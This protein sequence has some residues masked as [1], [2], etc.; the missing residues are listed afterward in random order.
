[1]FKLNFEIGVNLEKS[2]VNETVR[3]QAVR[4]H[5]KRI[6]DVPTVDGGIFEMCCDSPRAHITY[7]VS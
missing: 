1:M 4:V 6:Y 5:I 3:W 2:F 7:W